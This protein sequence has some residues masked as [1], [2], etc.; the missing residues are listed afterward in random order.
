MDTGYDSMMKQKRCIIIPA[1][2]KN[3]VIPDQLVKKL[4]G[5]TLIQRAI[6]NAK[7][8][9][10]ANDIYVVTD[11]EE[12]SL[13]CERNGINVLYD[14]A[15][16]SVSLDIVS[17]LFTTL[18]DLSTKYG[19]LIIYRANC[20][21]VTSWDIEDAYTSFMARGCDCLVTVKSVQYR[22]WREIKENLGSLLFDDKKEE[23]YIETKALFMLTASALGKDNSRLQVCPYFLNSR[24]IEID[25][26]QD[27]WVCEKLLQ[28]KHV[29]FV[30]AGYPAIGMGHI[31]RALMLAHEISDHRITFLCTQESELA[32]SS[33]IAKDYSTKI[34]KNIDLADEVI[35]LKPDLVINDILSTSAEYIFRLKEYG[36][37]VVN[38]EDDGEGAKHA[39]L[40]VNALYDTPAE[41]NERFLYGHENFC[42]RDEFV[43]AK[44]M[45]FRDIPKEVLI[46][47]GGTDVDDFTR[48][49][50]DAIYPLC[51]EKN[52]RISLVAGPGYAHK[53]SLEER[54]N[55]LNTQYSSSPFVEFTHTTNIMS[56]YM[57]R[58]DFAICSA[59]RTVYE[60]THMR[61]PG[62]VMSHHEREDMHTFAR[63]SNGFLYLG[64]MKPFKTQ[65]LLQAFK[66]MIDITSRKELFM[67]QCNF[68]FT[69]NKSHLVNRLLSLLKES[70][71]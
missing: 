27:W 18:K 71:A 61:V 9:V 32:A 3:T 4:A 19:H 51:L 52:I 50:L 44:Q 26:Y 46:T 48:Q 15:Y 30:V 55:T 11:S 70:S 28:S 17:S 12:V 57:E 45:K 21:L 14:E 6:D 54:V 47:F 38:F 64:I 42:L 31:Y 63:R 59:G 22:L 49:T 8:V 7:H 69:E 29:V 66:Q 20:P 16:Q 62:I 58:A 23:S 2:K 53:Y 33:I 1:I 34:Q 40:V 36:A 60:L 25:S 35:A 43:A 24:S 41:N 5:K 13:I 68:D 65:T 37:K 39:D 56:Q 10:N 67:S